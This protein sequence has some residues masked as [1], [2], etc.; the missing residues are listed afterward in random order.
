MGRTTMSARRVLG[1]ATAVAL[2]LGVSACGGS[3]GGGKAS[4][5]FTYWSMWRA[6]EPQAKVLKTAI[7]DFTAATGAKVDVT[8][9]GRDIAKKIGPA[10]AANQAPDLWDESDDKVYGTTAAAGQTSHAVAVSSC[11]WEGCVV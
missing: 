9:A 4:G 5:S 8:W 1:A 7:D 11:G 6:D 10:I 3:G 2:A